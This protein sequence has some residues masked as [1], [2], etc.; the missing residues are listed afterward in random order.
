MSEYADKNGGINFGARDQWKLERVQMVGD[1]LQSGPIGKC[2]DKGIRKIEEE[3]V[4][5]MMIEAG[6]LTIAGDV[7][8]IAICYSM[9]R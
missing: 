9:Q 5:T 6:V 2:A 8:M 7:S 4:M 1:R 3:S